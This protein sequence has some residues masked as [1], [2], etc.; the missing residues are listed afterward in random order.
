MARAPELGRWGST[1]TG[2]L[3]FSLGSSILFDSAD[4]GVWQPFIV[5]V[6]LLAARRVGP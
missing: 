6:L 5:P 1:L 2:E 4:H 3:I